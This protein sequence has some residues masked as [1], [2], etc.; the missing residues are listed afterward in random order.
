MG[1]N[2][3]PVSF[4]ILYFNVFALEFLAGGVPVD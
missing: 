2:C 3:S 1:S 4:S